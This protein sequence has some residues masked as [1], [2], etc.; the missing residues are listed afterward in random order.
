M[1]KHTVFFKLKHPSGS[2]A[3]AEFLRAAM[4]LSKIADVRGLECVRQVSGKN[5]F[6]WGLL[7]GFDDQAAYD[8]YNQHRDHVAFVATRWVPEVERFLEIDY[9]SEK[10]LAGPPGS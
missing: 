6:A 3:E 8:R 10:S 1:I 2:A 4:T 5:D 7:M 9:V